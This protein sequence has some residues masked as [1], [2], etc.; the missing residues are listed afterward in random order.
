[1]AKKAEKN[2]KKDEAPSST[3]FVETVFKFF[4]SVKTDTVLSVLWG[5]EVLLFAILS[6]MIL[7]GNLTAD[8]RFYFALVI[9]GSVVATFLISAWRMQAAPPQAKPK[10]ASKNRPKPLR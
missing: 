3:G 5:V 2:G 4:S 1:M 10:S 9:V 7:F 8:Q 6:L